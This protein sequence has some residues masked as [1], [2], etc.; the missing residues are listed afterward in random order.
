MVDAYEEAVEMIADARARSRGDIAVGEA[1]ADG[2]VGVGDGTVV[3]VATDDEGIAA[4]PLDEG[5]DAV[6]LWPADL[7]ALGQLGEDQP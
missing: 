6:G 7:T 1:A 2:A 5:M 4:V 3:E